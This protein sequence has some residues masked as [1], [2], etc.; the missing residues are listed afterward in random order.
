MICCNRS[1]VDTVSVQLKFL[2]SELLYD[3]KNYAYIESDLMG[4][5][6]Q[7]DKLVLHVKHLLADIGEKGNVDRVSRILS[8]VHAEVVEMLYPY[9]KRELTQEEITDILEEPAVYAVDM[10]VPTTMSRTTINY[11]SKLIHE[12]MVYRVMADW[13]SM[14]YR[15]VSS[16]WQAK[17]DGLKEDINRA[18]SHRRTNLLRTS[19]PY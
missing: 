12:Y 14:T 17:A 3:I 10:N 1:K 4:A 2:R 9:T 11:L 13:T 8:L 16:I 7:D 19:S 5:G 18:K 6:V 15:E